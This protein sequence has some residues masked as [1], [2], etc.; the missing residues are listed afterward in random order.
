MMIQSLC[1]KSELTVTD[2]E[3]ATSNQASFEEHNENETQQAMEP[4]RHLSP[5]IVYVG[6]GFDHTIQS[7]TGGRK[8]RKRTLHDDQSTQ[9]KAIPRKRRNLRK[10]GK[11]RTPRGTG[12]YENMKA[13]EIDDDTDDEIVGHAQDAEAGAKVD[14]NNAIEGKSN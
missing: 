7:P 10:D 11:P 12:P 9:M 5:E 1:L 6:A 2:A 4:H 13:A 14:D 8:P 3:P